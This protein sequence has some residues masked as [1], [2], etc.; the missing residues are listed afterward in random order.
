[1]ATHTLR[2]VCPTGYRQGQ[3]AY[4][5]ETVIPVDWQCQIN[6]E[7]DSASYIGTAP[8]WRSSQTPSWDRRAAAS[9]PQDGWTG[10]QLDG[11]GAV[12]CVQMCPDVL[13]LSPVLTQ[14]PRYFQILRGIFTNLFHDG[15]AQARDDLLMFISVPASDA[16]AAL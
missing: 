6:L 1:M 12:G 2:L 7:L 14:V 11:G 16:E 13:S 10:T 15:H 4:A 3:G 8:L 5:L 9:R